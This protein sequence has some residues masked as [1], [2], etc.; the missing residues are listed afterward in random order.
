[1]RKVGWQSSIRSRSQFWLQ[2][3]EDIMEKEEEERILA[4]CW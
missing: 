2:V 3:G 1:M 4:M